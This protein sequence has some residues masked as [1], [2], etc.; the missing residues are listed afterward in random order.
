KGPDLGFLR[1]P[2]ESIGWIKAK[3]SFYNL[4]KRRKDVL[5]N[6]EPSPSRADTITGMIHEFTKDVSGQKPRVRSISFSAIFCGVRL[7]A[8]RF[9]DNYELYF[10]EPT[11]DPG[12]AL[13]QSFQGTS[14]GSVWRFY[15]V[16]KDGAAEVIDRRLLAVPFYESTIH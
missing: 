5:S 3:G 9:L 2:N 14:G 11:N 8:L 16:E 6:T 12:F 15:V 1:L 13:P 4:G 7:I 10:F